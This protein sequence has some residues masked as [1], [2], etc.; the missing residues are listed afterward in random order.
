MRQ[1]RRMGLTIAAVG[2]IAAAAAGLLIGLPAVQHNRE[3]AEISEAVKAEAAVF[4]AQ[5]VDPAFPVTEPLVS[6][7]VVSGPWSFGLLVTR[8]PEG[9]HAE[10]DLKLFITRR[11]ESTGQIDAAIEYTPAFYSYIEQI[12]SGLIPQGAR[13]LLIEAAQV[14]R[15]EAAA[16]GLYFALP[17]EPGQTWTMTGGPH[18]DS[19]VGSARPWSALDFA[20]GPGV[21]L[22]R[23]AESG[24]VWRS[25]DCPNFIRVDHAGGYRTGYY[26]VVN[27]RVQNGQN[28]LRG[29]P[30]ANEGM[31]V[32]CG[33]Y[34]TG[35]H[36]H[37]SLRYY[38]SRLD[39]GGTELSGWVVRDGDHTYSGCMRRISDG[40]EVCTPYAAVLH[41]EG[42][43]PVISD[44]RYDWNRDTRADLWVV[45]LRPDDGGPVILTVY[46][47]SGPTSALSVPRSSLPPQPESLNTAFAAGDH[48]GDGTPDLWVVHRRLDSSGATALRILSGADPQYLIEDSPT[49]FGYLGDEVRFAV[50]DYDRDG[51]LDLYAIIPDYAA[52]TVRVRVVN[53]LDPMAMIG[54]RTASIEAPS[55][56][57]D[58]SFALADYDRDGKADLWVIEPHARADGKTRVTILEG[59][60]F[61]N[62]LEQDVLPL[63]PQRS[64]IH[65][66]SWIVTDYNRDGTPDIWHVNRKNGV[67][68]IVSGKNMTSMLY[69]GP[70]GI[71]KVHK[72]D[73]QILGSDRARLPIPPEPPQLIGPPDGVVV[74]DTSIELSYH[75]SGLAK[76]TSLVMSDAL[77]GVLAS[78]NAPKS[79]TSACANDTCVVDTAAFGLQMRDGVRVYW[80]VRATNAYGTTFSVTRSFIP[81]LPGPVDILLPEE[82]Q[83]LSV[84]P[85]FTWTSRPTASD[86]VVTIKNTVTKE[87]VK[88]TFSQAQCTAA[89]TAQLPTPLAD[90]SYWVKVKSRD[91]QG[92][93][94][95]SAKHTF[96]LALAPPT[97]APVTTITPTATATPTLDPNATL[98]VPGYPQGFRGL[99]PTPEAGS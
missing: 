20:W 77:G 67:L 88:L 12:P 29:D 7:V 10:P 16:P 65:R 94:S 33:G 39:I 87:K 75:P 21:G 50:A 86:Y 36:V 97:A 81:D 61:Q 66:F 34:T 18:P 9:I 93:V 1:R 59:N 45:D 70:T 63:S 76:S 44:L 47:G 72:L 2:L 56:Y 96:T 95:M 17:W 8:A 5:T 3:I 46:D 69:D 60:N 48:D 4:A 40:Y 64:D 62:V 68:K 6:D 15:G 49:A 37:F 35:P 43:L 42:V 11:D 99:D 58:V 78:G 41:G 30:L 25:S 31:G 92:G 98:P 19:G 91:L 85:Q 52:D 23:A 89:C 90:G 26:H 54:D 13:D 79:H 38:D 22:V 82:G 80:N 14:A 57:T 74:T 55:D 73:Y 28:V 24:V 71:S 84:Q 32:G 51:N 27:E 53:G 83:A